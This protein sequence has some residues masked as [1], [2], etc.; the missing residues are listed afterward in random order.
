MEHDDV[1]VARAVEIDLDEVRPRIECRGN[2]GECVLDMRGMA[3]QRGR[4]DIAVDHVQARVDPA[5]RDDLETGDVQPAAR[6]V[7]Q[8]EHDRGYDREDR[9][10]ATDVFH[11]GGTPRRARLFR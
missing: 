9:E 1:T 3:R 6:P 7:A 11:G 8:Q 2:R 4:A 10:D 5:V